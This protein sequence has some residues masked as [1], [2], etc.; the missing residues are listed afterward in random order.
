MIFHK[1]LLIVL[2]FLSISYA[3]TVDGY[4]LDAKTSEPLPNC[5]I[6]VQNTLRGAI[7]NNEGYFILNMENDAEITLLFQ[8]IGYETAVI[9]IH[10]TSQN[11][12][13]T[14]RLKPQ[15]LN[16]EV[17]Y[18]YGNQYS[19]VEQLI[20]K[21]SEAKRSRMNLLK[22]FQCESYSKTTLSGQK[23]SSKH[24]YGLI[25]ESYSNIIWNKP[26]YIYETVLSQKTTANMPKSIHVFGNKSFPNLNLDNIPFGNKKIVGP[27]SPDAIHY[28][29]YEIA[30]TLYQDQNRIF[31]IKI[32]PK[33]NDKPLMSGFIYL[34]DVLYVI[35][36]VDLRLNENCNYDFFENI[37]IRQKY[38]SIGD[39]I[40]L[41]YFSKQTSDWVISFPAYPRL[42]YSKTTFRENYQINNSELEN[43]YGENNIKILNTVQYDAI[44]MHIPP[45]TTAE[46]KGYIQLDS[47]I[48]NNMA[49]NFF[50]RS[51]KS[52]DLFRQLKKLPIGD[53]SDFYRF[54]KVEGNYLG[55]SFHSKKRISPFELKAAFGYGFNDKK[56]KYEISAGLNRKIKKTH[57]AVYAAYFNKIK[58]RELNVELPISYNTFYSLLS[59]F[60]YFDYYYSKGYSLQL[61]VTPKPF[62]FTGA[63]SLQENKNAHTHMKTGLFDNGA[64][65]KN[66]TI[67]EGKISSLNLSAKYSNAMYKETFTTKSIL[68]RK[69]YF[70]TAIHYEKSL[71]IAGNAFNYHFIHL[72]LYAKMNT[73]SN[74]TLDIK[75][76]AGMGGAALPLQKYFELESGFSGYERFKTF[77]TLDL[78]AFVGNKKLALFTEHNFQNSLFRL[79]KI[80]YI[81]SLDYD[82]LFITNYGWAGNQSFSSLKTGDFYGEIG[83]GV[84]R[85]FK[86]FKLEFLWPITKIKKAKPFMLSLKFTEIEF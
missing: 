7:S 68:K 55:G 62:W 29:R 78:N 75:F 65:N 70:E 66:I 64:F 9:T 19:K 80:P 76:E 5:N 32:W 30:D 74:G 51:V 15:T 57:F 86:L 54:N 13:L 40:F 47:L 11:K 25:Y 77:R 20:L 3:S 6:Q 2:S 22:S 82:I 27:T 14:I 58:T 69:N 18:V 79:S 17:I 8:Y 59:S 44:P 83:F 56:E 26:D 46:Q 33:R 28:Y 63:I 50:T 4:I 35:T 73:Y 53:L 10:S 67:N 31:K 45:L 37:H 1:T 38:L 49:L 42:K 85:I 48:S 24:F 61:N 12:P 81:E 52:M 21:A 72:L 36:E 23:D 71:N 60:D 84:G 16:S 39:S 34:V 41:P 43:Y